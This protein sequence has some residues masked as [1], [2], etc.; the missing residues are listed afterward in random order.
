MNLQTMKQWNGGTREEAGL[1]S[2][3][4]KISPAE[5]K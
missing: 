3:R 2:A 1:G 4:L 5:N